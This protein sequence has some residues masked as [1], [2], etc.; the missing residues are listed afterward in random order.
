MSFCRYCGRKLEEGE[1]CNCCGQSAE[2]SADLPDKAQIQGRQ[3]IRTIWRDFIYLLKTPVKYGASYIK[4]GNC[5]AALSFLVL[6]G[7]CSGLFA[8]LC[9]GKIN[10]VISLGGSITEG[11][12]F[13]SAGAFFLT[14]LYSIILSGILVCLFFGIGKM[15]KGQ[16]SFQEALCIASLRSVISSPVSLVSCLIFLLNIPAGI[17]L[18]YFA[19]TLLGTSFLA[20]GTEG[21][22]GMSREHKFYLTLSVTLL[23][24][25]IFL[26]FVSKVWPNYLPSSIR[27][28]FSWDYIMNLL[29]TQMM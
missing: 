20:N 6:H 22:S 14:L 10:G 25:L 11:L 9:V 23:F 24:V 17:I 8:L 28:I 19:G 16:I 27:S 15:M 18:Y 4:R 29:K 2:T 21:I 1:H 3:L 26:L 13:S 12:K 5:A 7:L